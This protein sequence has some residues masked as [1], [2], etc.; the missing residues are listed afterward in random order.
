[1]RYDQITNKSSAELSW[2]AF[3]TTD[4]TFIFLLKKRASSHRYCANSIQGRNNYTLLTGHWVFCLFVYLLVGWG[5]F[6][7]ASIKRAR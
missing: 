3:S 7:Q 2:S 5:F 1:M 4:K 6:W